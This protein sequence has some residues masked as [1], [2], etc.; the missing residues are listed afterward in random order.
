M[1]KQWTAIQA[2]GA[3]A[4][5][6][7]G[8]RS[9]RDFYSP[10][11]QLSAKMQDDA[12]LAVL[13]LLIK[14]C[15]LNWSNLLVYHIGHLSFNLLDQDE[16]PQLYSSAGLLFKPICSDTAKTRV[17]ELSEKILTHIKVCQFSHRIS[18]I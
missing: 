1:P 6:A 9:I 18:I 2:E 3:A 10:Q 7:D 8:Q 5:N 4:R 14:G 11:N 13:K 12:N 17:T 16:F 15:S